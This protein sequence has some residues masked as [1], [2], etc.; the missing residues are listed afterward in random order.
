M[1]LQSK[2][3]ISMVLTLYLLIFGFFCD[4]VSFQCARSS[5]VITCFRKTIS[6]LICPRISVQTFTL[7]PI[8]SILRYFGTSSHTPFSCSVYFSKFNGLSYGSSAVALQSFSH[9]FCTRFLIFYIFT[10]SW[11]QGSSWPNVF[12]NW[13][14]FI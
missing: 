10:S 11:R 2:T 1:T 14:W 8:C 7:L 9:L 4:V 13:F 5:P 3:E 6:L 12:L